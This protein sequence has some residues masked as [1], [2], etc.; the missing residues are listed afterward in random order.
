MNLT[1]YEVEALSWHFTGGDE[2]N[3]EV[4]TAGPPGRNLNTGLPKCISEMLLTHW[5]FRLTLTQ[6]ASGLFRAVFSQSTEK[7]IYIIHYTIYI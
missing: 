2:E 1:K 7:F 3:N 5:R 4:R 6:E